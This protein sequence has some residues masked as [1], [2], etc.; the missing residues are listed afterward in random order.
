MGP[1][2]G[3]GTLGMGVVAMTT[4]DAG[5]RAATRGEKSTAGT[6]LS[7]A[8]RRATPRVAEGKRI[9]G[10][11]TGA[12]P[13]RKDGT[14]ARQRKS[15]AGA[16]T[17]VRAEDTR[18]EGEGGKA[19]PRAKTTGLWVALAMQGVTEVR[20]TGAVLGR[21][22][23]GTAEWRTAEEGTA[24]TRGAAEWRRAAEER[25]TATRGEGG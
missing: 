7:Q 21:V 1:T 10:T 18:T 22:T 23:Q 8:G 5:M 15:G 4:R 14:G 17:G 16:T 25:R 13:L 11:A 9:E 19:F 12:S 24:A 2:M 3:A 20:T 6:G